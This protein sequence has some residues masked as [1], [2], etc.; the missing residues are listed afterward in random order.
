MKGKEPRLESSRRGIKPFLTDFDSKYRTVGEIE[1]GPQQSV[2][3]ASSTLRYEIFP[4]R[5]AT[6]ARSTSGP[7]SNKG[8]KL[9]LAL[10]SLFPSGLALSPKKQVSQSANV[11]R[12][13]KSCGQAKA[14]SRQTQDKKEYQ[15]NGKNLID[16]FEKRR[17]Q[18][19]RKSVAN[20]T[21][22][23]PNEHSTCQNPK[24]AMKIEC[25]S[26]VLPRKQFGNTGTTFS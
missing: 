24:L 5:R 17:R 6:S 19:I 20:V 8:S 23:F 10:K 9:T 3:A 14:S 2:K 1:M 7:P 25:K 26:F 4:G 13:G 11:S 22:G 12:I 15:I 18:I 16:P 21:G